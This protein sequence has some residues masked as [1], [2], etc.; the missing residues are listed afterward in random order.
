MN[1]NF[2]AML[3]MHEK[4]DIKLSLS[5]SDIIAAARKEFSNADELIAKAKEL[6]INGRDL[7]KDCEK[8]LRFPVLPV[9]K[10]DGFYI[11]KHTT[12][13]IPYF[14]KHGFFEIV[15]VCRGHCSQLL[16]E[17]NKLTLKKG[18]LCILAPGSIHA[19][20]KCGNK[21]VIIKI[22]IPESYL[23]PILNRLKAKFSEITVCDVGDTAEYL[24]YKLTEEYLRDDEYSSSALRCYTELLFAELLRKSEKPDI[25][26]ENAVAEYLGNNTKCANLKNF[27]ANLGFSE[28]YTS[29]LLKER[30]GKNFT[31]TLGEFRLNKAAELLR[32]TD[33]SIERIAAEIGYLNAAGLYKKFRAFYGMTPGAYRRQ[34]S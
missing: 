14:H 22:D 5:E 18:Q 19:I 27:A 30:T 31:E 2:T 4:E 7:F 29:R 9:K 28:A 15:Y 12:L 33:L 21:D 6:S 23:N 26:I 17:D 32:A 10:I 25:A 3:D 8:V 13:Q 1:K 11:H 24:I 20:E 34:F 16:A